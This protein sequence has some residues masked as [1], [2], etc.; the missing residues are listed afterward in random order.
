MCRLNVPGEWAHT[1]LPPKWE[2]YL[3]QYWSSCKLRSSLSLDRGTSHTLSGVRF[4]CSN[5]FFAEKDGVTGSCSK[6]KHRSTN[7]VFSQNSYVVGILRSRF[8]AP[9]IVN[10]L[11]LKINTKHFDF[12]YRQ[13][14][15]VSMLCMYV[16]SVSQEIP[17]VY[18]VF[19]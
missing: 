9:N 10:N 16:L 11:D 8:R 12:Y 6:L 2:G 17:I 18:P 19:V 7:V 13:N 1:E 15:F 5:L 4:F 3:E 14:Y